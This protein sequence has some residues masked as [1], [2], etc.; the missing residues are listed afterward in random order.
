MLGVG[1]DSSQKLT[2][3]CM[4]EKSSRSHADR[5]PNY[6]LRDIRIAGSH[7]MSH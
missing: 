3:I 2:D 6:T 5:L 4:H 1:K 7:S